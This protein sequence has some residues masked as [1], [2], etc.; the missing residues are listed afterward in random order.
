MMVQAVIK[1]STKYIYNELTYI[2][3]RKI[4]RVKVT[5]SLGVKIDEHCHGMHK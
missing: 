2:G 1:E 4:D 5:K 3:G